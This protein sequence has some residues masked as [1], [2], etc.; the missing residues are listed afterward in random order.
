VSTS[1][2]HPN[3]GLRPWIAPIVFVVLTLAMTWPLGIQFSEA[4]PGDGFDGWQNLWNLW[5]MKLSLVNR[6]EWP[7]STDMLYH[8]TGVDLHFH[9]LNPFNGLLSMP[10]QLGWGLLPAYNLIVLFSFAMGGYGSYLLSRYVLGTAWVRPCRQNAASDGEG[11]LREGR[12]RSMGSPCGWGEQRLSRTW[13]DMASLVA[14]C[15]FTFAPFHFAHLL[16]HMQVI[17]LE[18]LP[19]FILY[20]LRAIDASRARGGVDRTPKATST[21]SYGHLSGRV[22]LSKPRGWTRLHGWRDALL[23]GMFLALVGMCDWYYVMYCLLFVFL[24]L[25]YLAATKRLRA[26][27]VLLL[28]V[29]GTVSLALLSPM[30]VPMIREASRLDFMVPALEQTRTLSADLLAYFVPQQFHPIWGVK[31]ADWSSVFTASLSERSVFAGYVPILLALAGIAWSTWCWRRPARPMAS[32]RPG[33]SGLFGLSLV[34]FWILSLGPVLHVAGETALLPGKGEIPLPYA[35]L[36]RIVPFIN[37]SRSV[38]RFD[39]MVMLSLSVLAAVGLT[40]L[41]IAVSNVLDG[42]SGGSARAWRHRLLLD[43][44]LGGIVVAL[45]LFEFLAVP[46]P[47]SPPDTPE[48]YGTIADQP[49]DYAVLNLPM[50]WDRPG[51]LLYQTV[52]SKKLTVAYVSRN[53]PRTLVERAPVLQEL[54][55]LGPDVMVSDVGRLAPTVLNYLDV[56]YVVLDRY[57]MPAGGRERQETERL[58]ELMFDGQP[59]EYSDDRLTVYEVGSADAEVPFMILGEG[60]GARAVS[61]SRVARSIGSESTLIVQVP[62]EVVVRVALRAEC[63]SGGTLTIWHGEMAV[64]GFDIGIPEQRFVTGEI[65]LDRGSNLLRFVGRAKNGVPILISDLE[66]ISTQY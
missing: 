48:W 4:I 13:I 64:G 7:F 50:T 62:N 57:K 3:R 56:R 9:T 46:Y 47:M 66:L 61:G 18:W 54:R 15:V 31:A 6:I 8:P 1:T 37:V 38:S 29:T 52:H 44:V 27:S 34:G 45:V 39:V 26:R 30:V 55:Y 49:D 22:H 51:Y 36:Q 21:S 58:A 43:G 60:W 24:L 10:V 11:V 41:R 35:I 59:P 42:G 65:E 14:G 63:S 5:W 19:F 12:E 2:G 25:L 33:W 40:A 20:L 28:G 53:D 32:T 16:G 17:S 23:A